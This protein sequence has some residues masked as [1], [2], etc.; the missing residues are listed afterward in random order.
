MSSESVPPACA[1]AYQMNAALISGSTQARMTRELTPRRR[2]GIAFRIVRASAM[3]ITVCATMPDATT[4]ISVS[5][6]ACQKTGSWYIRSMLSR[7]V[8]Q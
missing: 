1:N 4:K 8:N 3:P 6:N 5:L 7:P 2:A